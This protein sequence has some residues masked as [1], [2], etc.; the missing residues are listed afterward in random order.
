M[1]CYSGVTHDELPLYRQNNFLSLY[2]VQITQGF[3]VESKDASCKT[4]KPNFR[5]TTPSALF[6]SWGR[7]DFTE[8]PELTEKIM[9]WNNAHPNTTECDNCEVFAGSALSETVFVPRIDLGP[10]HTDLQF[11]INLDFAMSIIKHK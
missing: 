7:S 1:T 10:T 2:T 6:E 9:Q 11:P 8:K 3:T 4:G 5:F